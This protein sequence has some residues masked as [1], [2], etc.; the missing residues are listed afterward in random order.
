MRLYVVVEGQTEAAFVTHVLAPHLAIFSVTAVPIIVTTRRDRSTGA[1]HR[2]GG[3]WRHWRRD[4]DMPVPAAPRQ[5]RAL[6]D[7]V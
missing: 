6:H 7:A 5:W 2:G 1:K 4:L 3:H